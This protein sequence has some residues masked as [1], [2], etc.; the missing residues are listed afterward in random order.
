MSMKVTPP[1]HDIFR[2]MIRSMPVLQA[3]VCEYTRRHAAV[4]QQLTT[5]DLTLV[6]RKR[7]F[8]DIDAAKRRNVLPNRRND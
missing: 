4:Y 5:H 1:S 2:R 6:E 3:I 7:W 8:V